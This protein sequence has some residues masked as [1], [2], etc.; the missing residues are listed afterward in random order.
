VPAFVK[1]VRPRFLT[2]RKPRAPADGTEPLIDR[3]LP[4]GDS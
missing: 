3:Q 1:V 2:D 4:S